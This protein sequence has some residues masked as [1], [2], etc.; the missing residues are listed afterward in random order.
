M[1]EA[2]KLN[3]KAGINKWSVKQWKT[4][5]KNSP[6]GTVYQIQKEKERKYKSD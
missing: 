5:E 1:K 4:G 2:D 3:F 6:E